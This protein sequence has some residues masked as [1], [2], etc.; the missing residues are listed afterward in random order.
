MKKNEVVAR[1]HRWLSYFYGSM[2]VV[3]VLIATVG[4]A[5]LKLS[6]MLPGILFFS[7]FIGIHFLTSVGAEKK[8]PWA[9]GLSIVLGIL[10]LF[11]FPIG[12]ILGVILL[13]NNNWNEA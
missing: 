10:M 8:E 4:G 5:G 11:G 2:L 6:A 12:T 13:T 3:V 9:R 1:V 7:V